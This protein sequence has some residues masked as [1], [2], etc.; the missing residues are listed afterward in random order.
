MNRRD[1][2]LAL[3]AIAAPSLTLAQKS[4][5]VY[6]IGFL[7]PPR[8]AGGRPHL[9]GFRKGLQEF[10]YV[11]GKNVAID[12]RF[13]E[14]DLSRLPG[15]A[16]DMVR[17]NPDVIVTASPPGV[18][19]VKD[20]TRTIPIVIAA[21]YD[22]V[23]QGFVESLGRPGGNITG[24]SVQYEDTIPKLLELIKA[25]VPVTTKIAVLKTVDPSHDIFVTRIS[26]LSRPIQI[27]I[28]PIEVRAPSDLADAF[29]GIGEGRNEA[30]M[31]LPHPIFNTRSD[32]V[33]RLAAARRV[34]AIYPFR[35]YAEAGGLMSLGI[36]LPA[37]FRR[38]A[39]FVDR[40]LK[41]AKPADLPMEQPNTI[42]L[43][44]NVKSAKALGITVPQ[45][46]LLR[47]DQVIE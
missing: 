45:S 32:E 36:D 17:Q 1:T 10:G 25:V 13:A 20:A 5:K 33:V 35:S 39:Y 40:I 44:V 22:P 8:E 30:L 24:L 42:D 12:V 37:S 16:A 3:L 6:R 38:A 9:D 27:Q 31:V 46:V 26:A 41:G 47:A 23:G 43:V 28:V 2:V 29:S 18:R 15:L 21:V 34:P 4:E 7:L 19:A 11:E 14:D